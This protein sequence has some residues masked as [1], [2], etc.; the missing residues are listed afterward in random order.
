MDPT[1]ILNLSV[2]VGVNHPDNLPQQVVG[3]LQSCPSALAARLVHN[4]AI[5]VQADDGLSS[6]GPFGAS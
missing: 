1:F 6:A 5:L 3:V 4:T 2:P